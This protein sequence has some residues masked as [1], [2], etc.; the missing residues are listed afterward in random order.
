MIKKVHPKRGTLLDI[1]DQRSHSKVKQKKWGAA[2]KRMF[3]FA[4]I[5]VSLSVNMHAQSDLSAANPG[6]SSS[7][8]NGVSAKRLTPEEAVNLAVK[9][10]MGLETSRVTM[11]A[12]KRANDYSWGYLIPNITLSSTLNRNNE[13]GSTVVT[14]PYGT[15]SGTAT[16]GGINGYLFPDIFAGEIA[17]PEW[18]IIGNIQISLTLSAALFDHFKRT[19]RDYEA[20]LIGYDKAKMQLER[21]VRKAY[22]N[23][24]L[25]QE[26]ITLMRG[27]FENVERQVQMAQANYNAGLAPELTLLQAR[28][29]RENMR[30]LID[31]VENGL[32]L[33]MAQFAMFLGLDVNTEFELVP[34]SNS[35][36][37]IPLD[38]AEMISKA[39]SSKPDIQELR[40]TI[41]MMQSARRMQFLALTPSL[42]LG[43]N[44]QSIFMRDPWKNSWFNGD[45]WKK[46]GSFSITIALRLHSLI[47]FTP[48]FQAIKT[49]DDQIATANIGLAQ[50]VTGTEIEVY[51][52]VLSLERTRLNAE[53]LAQTVSLAEQSFRLTEQAYRAGLQDYFHVQNAEQ[54]LR[55]A[56]VQLLEQHFNYLNGLIDLEYSTGVPFGTLSGRSR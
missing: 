56:R 13:T 54:S 31:Q 17:N 6:E 25:L 2:G 28:V 32:K 15:P 47:P 23:I 16:L 30:P 12:K 26:N 20:G 48:D 9:N 49:L 50:M 51:N 8:T 19:R 42:T 5:I 45:D 1:I 14:A 27:S 36:E 21:D 11:A 34:V 55:Q 24:L 35:I 52:T 39:A 7:E 18:N 38:V 4:A 53:A 33:S 46:S 22:H 44:S 3:I 37:F 40:Q 10:N 29:A 41:L 43:W